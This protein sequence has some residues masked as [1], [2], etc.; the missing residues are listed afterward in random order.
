MPEDTPKRRRVVPAP[1][2]E[3]GGGGFSPPALDP[4]PPVFNRHLICSFSERLQ[5]AADGALLAADRRFQRRL[6]KALANGS[7]DRQQLAALEQAWFW[8]VFLKFAAGAR[9]VVAAGAGKAVR[10]RDWCDTV[11]QAAADAAGIVDH[12]R[13]LVDAALRSSPQWRRFQKIHEEVIAALASD[14]DPQQAT[15]AAEP[16]ASPSISTTTP[17]GMPETQPDAS[18]PSPEPAPR[19]RRV[20]DLRKRIEAEWP[21]LKAKLGREPKPRDVA[22][23]VIPGFESMVGK[24]R[25]RKRDLCGSAVKRARLN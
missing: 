11:Y 17:S 7:V 1:P 21:G 12:Y 20:E 23:T 6:K 3:L 15:P 13:P 8:D 19:G 5:V 18:P 25:T 10:F 9:D 24:E 16:P 2:T 22:Q 14:K 4:G